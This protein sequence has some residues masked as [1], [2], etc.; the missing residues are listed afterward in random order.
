MRRNATL[1]AHANLEYYICF[2]YVLVFLFSGDDL[3]VDWLDVVTTATFRMFT[4]GWFLFLSWFAV[5][6][7]LW[8]LQNIPSEWVSTEELV[9]PFWPDLALLAAA[10]TIGMGKEDLCIVTMLWSILRPFDSKLR[11]PFGFSNGALEEHW[12]WLLYDV[13]E[14]KKY[15]EL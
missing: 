5:W 6:L 14:T 7:L 11:L 9:A 3:T 15:R 13:S 8:F 10:I 4:C 2:I 12:V 1:L